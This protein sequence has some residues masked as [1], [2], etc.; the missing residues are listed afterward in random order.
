MTLSGA[1]ARAR[2]A[3]FPTRTSLEDLRFDHQ[4]GPK[5]DSIAHPA[6]GAFL[7]EASN[8][9]LLGPPGTSQNAAKQRRK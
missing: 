3:G 7:T 9:V 8:I 1:E 2:A 6:T 5:R 4:P